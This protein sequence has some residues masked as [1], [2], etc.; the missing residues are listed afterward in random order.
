ML[1]ELAL[2][3]VERTMAARK[4]D[5]T[6]FREDSA[7][8]YLERWMLFRKNSF[9]NIYLHRF[10]ASDNPTP[11]DHPYANLSWVLSTGYYEILA[12]ELRY[13]RPGS[14]VFRRPT[15]PHRIILSE[16]MFLRKTEPI[17]VLTIF[18]HGPRVR[19]WG[20]HCPRGWVRWQDFVDVRPGEH[21]VGRGCG[22]P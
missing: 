7:G 17:P 21:S 2:R 14:F 15:T 12:G 5:L 18:L 19:D 9:G 3:F 6:I 4:P 13:R 1:L 16:D 20:F 11:H 8:P 22:E 10:S